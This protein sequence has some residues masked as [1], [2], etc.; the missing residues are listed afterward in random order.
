MEFTKKIKENFPQRYLGKLE[1]YYIKLKIF[2]WDVL[3]QFWFF[4]FGYFRNTKG[5]VWRKDYKKI[6]DIL[7]KIFIKLLREN[8]EKLLRI[9]SNFKEVSE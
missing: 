8:F 9:K 2:I 5:K 6:T 7:E 4:L 1:K 3:T